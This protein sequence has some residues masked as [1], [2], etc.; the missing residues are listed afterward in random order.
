MC[1]RAKRNVI[2]PND[3]RLEKFFENSPVTI[4]SY[5]T[6]RAIIDGGNG[7]SFN[8]YQASHVTITNLNCKGNGRESGNTE[9]GVV[10]YEC[11]NIKYEYSEVHGFQHSGVVSGLSD[12]MSTTKPPLGAGMFKNT[13][14][15]SVLLVNIMTFEGE[16]N[17]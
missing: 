11:D 5:G 16:I 1:L 8:I 17:L 2:D 13:E 3:C 14:S 15:V 10:I 7:K 6:G 4:T 9:N 12:D